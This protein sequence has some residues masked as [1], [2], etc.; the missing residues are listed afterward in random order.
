MKTT[1]LIALTILI[2]IVLIECGPCD[3]IVIPYDGKDRKYSLKEI[4]E[5]VLI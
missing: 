1:L 3:K 5:F 2:Q 4:A